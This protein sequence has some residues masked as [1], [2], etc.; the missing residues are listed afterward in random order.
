MTHMVRS[1]TYHVL[2]N[3]WKLKRDEMAANGSGALP[4]LLHVGM[5]LVILLCTVQVETLIRT[6][7]NFKDI[8]N[9]ICQ[10]RGWSGKDPAFVQLLNTCPALLLMT[11]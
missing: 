4:K 10:Y 8:Q 1:E 9:S 2:E 11:L 3:L 6:E 5:F 7:C